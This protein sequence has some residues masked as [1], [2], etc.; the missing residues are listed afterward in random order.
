MALMSSL[1]RLAAAC[2][3]LIFSSVVFFFLLLLVAVV[4]MEHHFCCC[5]KGDHIWIAIDLSL[6]DPLTKVFLKFCLLV[7]IAM[8]FIFSVYQFLVH[9]IY[10]IIN[11]DLL[12]IIFFRY[13]ATSKNTSALLS[14]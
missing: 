12:C 14:S 6:Y 1:I 11:G 9:K 8:C 2:T 13:L 4:I 5:S 10:R 7:G 3:S